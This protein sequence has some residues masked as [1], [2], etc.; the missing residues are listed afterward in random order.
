MRSAAVLVFALGLIGASAGHAADVAGWYAGIYAGASTRS[1]TNLS[2]VR[3]SGG[4]NDLSPFRQPV[5]INN[6]EFLPL[7]SRLLR[8]ANLMLAAHD[9]AQGG[10]VSGT[11]LDGTMHFDP[12]LTLD[13][14]IGYNLGNGGRIEAHYAGAE[15]TPATIDLQPGS[16]LSALG[17]EDTSTGIWTWAEIFA[18]EDRP[19]M[20]GPAADIT[21]FTTYYTRAD[22]FLVDGWYDFDTGTAISPYLGGGLGIARISSHATFDCGCGSPTLDYGMSSQLVPAAELGGGL[23]VELADPVTLDLAYRY[24]M[25]ANSDVGFDNLDLDG[26]LPTILSVRQTGPIGIHALS[27]GLIF[28]LN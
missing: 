8:V 22:F 17:S 24:R 14:A 23:R 16:F 4:F 18:P 11:F 10:S 13:I 19:G 20:T 7:D 28:A 6:S 27:A 3:V 9:F 5:E 12:A 2:T 26:F 21:G 15:F 25:A 1:D